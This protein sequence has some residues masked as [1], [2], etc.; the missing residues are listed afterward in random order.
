[1]EYY[2][3]ED[4]YYEEDQ[5][6]IELPEGLE[7][8]VE[9]EGDVIGGAEN[10]EEDEVEEEDVDPEG[11]LLIEN[12]GSE[13]SIASVE[14]KVFIT[15]DDRITSDFLNRYELTR[16]ISI[17][18]HR[19]GSNGDLYVEPGD[20]TNAIDIAIN[21]LKEG[22]CM[23]LLLRPMTQIVDPVTKKIKKYYEVW[24]PNEMRFYDDVDRRI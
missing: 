18:A 6:E 20:K 24:D 3:D 14:E 21:Q 16:L 5:E 12:D 1:M 17:M 19:I 11:V 23:Y 9:I 10:V 13:N 4:E 7:D 8:G 2:S 15:G 22:K